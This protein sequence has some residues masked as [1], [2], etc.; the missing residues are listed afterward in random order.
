TQ[1]VK[2]GADISV[3]SKILGHSR[4]EVTQI[5]T[6]VAGVEMKKTHGASHPR[7]K[8]KQEIGF[9]EIEAI[10]RHEG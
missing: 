8:E 4:L 6:Q 5:Y 7:E 10:R 1:M 3:V 2:N 9:P